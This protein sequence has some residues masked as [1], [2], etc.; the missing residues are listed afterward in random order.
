[1]SKKITDLSH[2]ISEYMTVYP[3]SEKPVIRNVASIEK[4]GYNELCLTC[5]THAG[6]HIDAPFHIHGKGK[7]LDIYDINTF[8]GKA[9]VID[10]TGYSIIERKLIED[11][12]SKKE[13]PQFLLFYTGWDL[14]WSSLK[15]FDN[16]PLLSKEAV[17]YIAQLPLNGVG[18]DAPSYDPLDIADFPN[19]K[20]LLKSGFVL[21][22]NLCKLNLINSEEVLFA[23]F[24]LKINRADASPVRAVAFLQRQ[25]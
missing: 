21:V 14:Y 18:I 3:N 15:Y 16:Y 17:E 20:I 6:T 22:E 8:F 5:S 10:C 11:S 23:C 1:M 13:I 12:L 2:T 9:L 19:H 25:K 7:T 24:P 4:H